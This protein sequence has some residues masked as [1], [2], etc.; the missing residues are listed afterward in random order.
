MIR[1]ILISTILLV[2][3]NVYSQ[4]NNIQQVNTVNTMIDNECKFAP[5]ALTMEWINKC[6]AYNPGT[7]PG[8]NNSNN[9]PDTRGEFLKTFCAKPQDFTIPVNFIELCTENKNK[10]ENDWPVINGYQLNVDGRCDLEEFKQLKNIANAVPSSYC[11]DLF[12][13]WG[14]AVREALMSN[15]N[16]RISHG[17]SDIKWYNA[18]TNDS[19]NGNMSCTIW[20]LAYNNCN[21]RVNSRVIQYDSSN[22]SFILK[23]NDIVKN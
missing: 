13:G 11:R 12:I 16:V 8:V 6:K 15:A 23:W 17:T 10:A 9:G 20:D 5:K 3:C 2:S 18:Y 1:K 21:L 19:R 22:G 7:N 14:K 4:S